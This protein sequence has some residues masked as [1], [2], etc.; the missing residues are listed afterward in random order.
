MQP[1]LLRELSSERPPRNAFRHGHEPHRLSLRE[2]GNAM[3]HG[4]RDNTLSFRVDL[5]PRL[6]FSS[7]SSFSSFVLE[8]H[9]PESRTR[10]SRSTR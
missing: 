7:S 8:F 5:P 4:M 10:T 9:P 2:N 1:K 3:R 6:S